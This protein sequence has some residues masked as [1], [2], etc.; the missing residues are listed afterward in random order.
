MLTYFLSPEQQDK[1]VL[2]LI[3]HRIE[4]RSMLKRTAITYHE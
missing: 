2:S 3:I 1:Y 4:V